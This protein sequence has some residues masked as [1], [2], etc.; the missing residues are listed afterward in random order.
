M[1]PTRD[2][3]LI[4]EQI[5][6]DLVN[7]FNNL[8]QEEKEAF[9]NKTLQI[10][11]LAVESIDNVLA[12]MSMIVAIYRKYSEKHPEVPI[13]KFTKAFLKGTDMYYDDKW[14]EN[15]LPMCKAFT[16]GLKVSLCG[17]KSLEDCKSKIKN[18]LD[19][20]LPF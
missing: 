12:L 2:D 17:A 13:E 5:V 4:S 11:S 15:F 14:M 3:K 16:K 20:L 19:K 8:T 6:Q 7:Q 10:S 1:I 9:F 18:I